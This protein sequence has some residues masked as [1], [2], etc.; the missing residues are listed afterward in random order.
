[1]VWIIAIKHNVTMSN[2]N[3]TAIIFE[4]ILTDYSK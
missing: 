4:P 2:E 3:E 1:M